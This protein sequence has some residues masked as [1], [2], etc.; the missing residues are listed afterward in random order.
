MVQA[1]ARQ[2]SIDRQVIDHSEATILMPRI[3]E[4]F[5]AVVVRKRNG[6]VRIQV[7][8]PAVVADLDADDVSPGDRIVV[9][10]EGADPVAG[11]VSFV[12]TWA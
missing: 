9:R 11:Q 4:T 5:D 8:A 12:R 10:L 2:A 3:G 6:R 7:A 1:R